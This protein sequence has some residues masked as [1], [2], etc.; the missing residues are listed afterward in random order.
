MRMLRF[1]AMPFAILLS[2]AVLTAWSLGMANPTPGLAAEVRP[3]YTRAEDPEP[4]PDSV[5]KDAAASQVKHKDVD[6]AG[7]AKRIKTPLQ[8]RTPKLVDPAGAKQKPM[9]GMR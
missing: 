1:T 7:D 2:G 8:Q 3:G 6:Q 5:K 9:R 4:V